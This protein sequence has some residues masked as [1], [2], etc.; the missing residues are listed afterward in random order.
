MYVA[1]R[2]VAIGK[3]WAA[4][5]NQRSQEGASFQL[6]TE[7]WVGVSKRCKE[8]NKQ[9]SPIKWIRR[10]LS[11]LAPVA[12]PLIGR[13]KIPLLCDNNSAKEKPWT[14]Y[15]SPPNFLFPSMKASSFPYPVWALPVTCCGCRLQI[16]I[17][18]WSPINSCWRN[19]WQSICLGQ[20]REGKKGDSQGII[21]MHKEPQVIET[22]LWR[23]LGKIKNS[24][25]QKATKS[26]EIAKKSDPADVMS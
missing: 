4:P 12:K 24:V 3:K 2:Q 5:E 10:R 22:E 9:K 13:R 15:Y 17:L 25:T 8:I 6:R 26:D 16:A 1:R 19:N 7:G 23:V 20:Q 14:L 11:H 21:S 18:C